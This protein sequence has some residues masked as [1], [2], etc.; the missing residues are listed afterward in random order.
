MEVPVI[1]SPVLDERDAAGRGGASPRP[2][3]G[4]SGC[5]ASGGDTDAQEKANSR[6]CCYFQSELNK[7]TL[8]DVQCGLDG[9]TFNVLYI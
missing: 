3:S 1:T 8:H 4:M 7:V 2:W 6:R 5:G 9:A